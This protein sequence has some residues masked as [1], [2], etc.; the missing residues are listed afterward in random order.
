MS[1]T[2]P[3]SKNTRNLIALLAHHRIGL[4]LDVGANIGQYASRLRHGG[5]RGPRHKRHRH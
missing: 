3:P 1:E 4:V 2:G 5:Y